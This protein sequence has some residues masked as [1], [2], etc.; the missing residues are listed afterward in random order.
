MTNVERYR[1]FEDEVDYKIVKSQVDEYNTLGS[2]LLYNGYPIV[3]IKHV[4]DEW[5]I[6]YDKGTLDLEF[7]YFSILPMILKCEILDHLKL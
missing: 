6:I 5:A 2:G 7:Q 3:E 1:V 4:Y